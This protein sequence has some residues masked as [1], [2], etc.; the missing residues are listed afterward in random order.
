MEEYAYL[1]GIP[2]SDRVPFCGLEG[3][4]ESQVITEAIHL[5]KFDVDANLTV[6]GGIIGLTSKFLMEKDFSFANVGSILAFETILALL[7]YGLV[8]FP[9]IENFVDV[10]AIRVFLVGNPTPCLFP[11]FKENKGCL[12]WSQRFMYLTNDNITRYSSI[13]DDVKIIGSCGEFTNVPLLG[14]QCGINYNS[15]L[16][17]RQVGFVM[18]D[19]PNNNLL[20]GLF[21]QEG[22][23]TQ[24]LKTR[25]MHDWHNIHR[26]EKSEIGLKN[27]VALEP[28]TS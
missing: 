21:F 28:Y 26:K 10:I 24:G 16:A 19:K 27:C 20:E 3:I 12:R 22:K 8:L 9:D 11:I 6:K 13:Y 5:K 1:L 4:L 14:T 18:R 7:I 17:R 23:D 2:V 25:M 15:A